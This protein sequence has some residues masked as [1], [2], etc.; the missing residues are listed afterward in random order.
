M[1]LIYESGW[2]RIMM[3]ED[4]LLIEAGNEPRIFIIIEG[5]M[6]QCISAVR[7]PVSSNKN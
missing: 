2:V 4:Q 5:M 1:L 3:Q 7:S 6:T